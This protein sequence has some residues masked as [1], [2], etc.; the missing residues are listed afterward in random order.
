MSRVQIEITLGLLLVLVTSFILVS[1]GFGEEDRMR[2]YALAQDG[3]A[4]EV[5]AALF[6]TNCSGCHGLTGEGIPGL[7]P[8][9]ND[10]PFFTDRLKEVGWSGTLEDYIVATVASGRL[11]STRPEQYAGGGKPAMP[12]WSDQFGGPLRQ[13]QIRYIASFVMNWEATAKGQVTLVEIASPV[14]ADPV[15]RGQLVYTDNGCTSCHTLGALSSG[16]VGPNLT[17]I[18]VTAVTRKDGLSAEDYLRQS[19]LNPNAYVVDTYPQDV[20]PKN[21]SEV[22]SPE[23]LDDLVAFLLAQK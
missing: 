17:Q 10:S 18:G 20:M 14:S 5:G 7:C 9:L 1:Y 11:Q 12:A 19:I 23:Q 2:E 3:R 4:I 16:V 22:T 6:E 8:P 15:E 13:D 21:F